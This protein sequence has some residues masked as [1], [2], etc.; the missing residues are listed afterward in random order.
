MAMLMCQL[1]P[2][3]FC[4]LSVPLKA[5]GRQL[6]HHVRQSVTTVVETELRGGRGEGAK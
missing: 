4:A 5:N 3:P 6:T 1:I 2:T